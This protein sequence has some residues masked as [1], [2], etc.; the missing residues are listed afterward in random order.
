MTTEMA[1]GDAKHPKGRQAFESWYL[2]A[3]RRWRLRPD[4]GLSYKALKDLELAH[5]KQRWN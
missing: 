1:R 5:H 3:A 4:P 2:G